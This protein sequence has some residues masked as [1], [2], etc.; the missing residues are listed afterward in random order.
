[1]RNLYESLLEDFKNLEKAQTSG[2]IRDIKKFLTTNYK[3]AIS[4]IKISKAPDSDG[5]YIAD[6]KGDVIISNKELDNLTNELFKF[7]VVD[8][9]FNCSFC[10]ITSLVGAPK[11]VKFFDCS[12]CQNLTSLEG[13]PEKADTFSCKSCGK[14]SSL[15]GA[16]EIVNNFYCGSCKITSLVGAPKEVKVF[17]CSYCSKLINLEGAPKKADEFVC[18]DC[19]SLRNLKGAPK[20]AKSFT[21]S[22]C[23]NLTSLEGAPKEV[24]YFNCD[25]CEELSS[26]KG[27]PDHITGEFTCMNCYISSLDGIGKID[28]DIKGDID[29]VDLSVLYKELK[30]N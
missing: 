10:K 25:D 7:G 9:N 2:V 14:L 27:C 4:K 11:E 5:K 19:E 1:M 15:M 16:P 8:G 18:S 12:Y 17:D 3:I 29:G 28:G 22:Y 13:A 20:K 26:F 23:I 30:S 6:I 21:C 24:D